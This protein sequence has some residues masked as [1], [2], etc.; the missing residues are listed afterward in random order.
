MPT[1]DEWRAAQRFAASVMA[2]WGGHQGLT[3][4]L[5]RKLQA[6]LASA[7]LGGIVLSQQAVLLAFRMACN[8]TFDLQL[9]R[10][11]RRMCEQMLPELRAAWRPPLG[12]GIEPAAAKE[13]PS[14]AG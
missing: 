11:G 4:A 10:L 7:G 3:Y 1:K 2:S 5:L 14:A 8:S 9:P 6:K 13:T 12:E